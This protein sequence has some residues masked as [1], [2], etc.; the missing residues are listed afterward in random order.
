MSDFIKM[1]SA[2]IQNTEGNV[3][4]V[5]VRVWVILVS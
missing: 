4:I 5:E 1:T 2:R 3:R